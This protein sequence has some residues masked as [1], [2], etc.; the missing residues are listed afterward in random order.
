MAIFVRT[1]LSARQK[2]A[3]ASSR[4]H[5]VLHCFFARVLVGQSIS[6]CRSYVIGPT[7]P[8][9]TNL[10]RARGLLTIVILGL[11]ASGCM[12]VEPA[13]SPGRT[14]AYSP[15]APGSQPSPI[16]IDIPDAALSSAGP[17]RPTTQ[18]AAANAISTERRFETNLELHQIIPLLIERLDRVATP[19]GA[20]TLAEFIEAAGARSA[21]SNPP[22]PSQVVVSTRA[23]GRADGTLRQWA[24][25]RFCKPGVTRYDEL[26]IET[27]ARWRTTTEVQC[28]D[29]VTQYIQRLNALTID[30]LATRLGAAGYTGI[31]IVEGQT[32]VGA[33]RSLLLHSGFFRDAAAPLL[34][35]SHRPLLDSAGQPASL[36]PA[37]FQLQIYFP[38]SAD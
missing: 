18:R 32:G 15:Y 13:A 30:V 20:A 26:R 17:S 5:G 28:S 38:A 29:C 10:E 3:S 2:R 9:R 34:A 35:A 4:S 12:S 19:G 37:V 8:L 1:R 21:A 23:C 24:E 14:W 22:F 16:A 31:G 27:F 36:P 25:T 33:F 7:V 6:S 11:A